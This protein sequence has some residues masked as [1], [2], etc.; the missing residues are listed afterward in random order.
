M[1][2]PRTNFSLLNTVMVS[3]SVKMRKFGSV[4]RRCS[5][6]SSSWVNASTAGSFTVTSRS[7]MPLGSVF[8]VTAWY[9]RRRATSIP[10]PAPPLQRGDARLQRLEPATEVGN[11]HHPRPRARELPGAVQVGAVDAQDQLGPGLHR[12]PDFS[13]V[14]GIDADAHAGGRELAHHVPKGRER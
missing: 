10:R 8:W 5:S 6:S 13:R 11:D 4:T 12:G 1:S 3:R 9:I 14:E 7:S 2:V